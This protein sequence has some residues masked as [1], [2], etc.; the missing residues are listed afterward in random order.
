MTD[1]RDDYDS[2]W[3]KAIS[4]YFPAFMKLFFPQIYPQI[5]WEKGY[6]FLDKEFQQIVRDAEI[7]VREADKLVKV[8]RR[9]DT[10]ILVL[11]HIEVQSQVQSEF[12]E[13]MYVWV[14][15]AKIF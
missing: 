13:R 3:K 5:N 8:W 1:K 7:G 6:E 14:T 9:D 4:L 10:E 15:V 2:P 11:L 12:A